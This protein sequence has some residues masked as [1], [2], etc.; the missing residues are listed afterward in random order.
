M[1]EPPP[2]LEDKGKINLC[3]SK[4]KMRL[5]VKGNKTISDGWDKKTGPRMTLPLIYD[6]SA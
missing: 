4:G 6:W 5:N 2:H 3:I 1:R